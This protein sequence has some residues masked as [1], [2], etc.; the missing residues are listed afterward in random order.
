MGRF[1]VAGVGIAGTAAARALTQRGHNVIVYN[2]QD[3]A[4]LSALEP[5][6]AD[7]VHGE[8]LP[9]HVLA[10]VD[11]V[12]VSPGFPPDHELVLA[13]KRAGVEVYSEPELAWR[14]RPS[15]AAPW[16]AVTGTNGKTTAVTMLAAMLAAAGY[17]SAALGNIGVPLVDAVTGEYDVLAVELSSQQLHWSSRLA[18]E[19]GALINLADD[20]LS[21][22]G[23]F[24]AYAQAKTAVWRGGN[25]VVNADD[26]RVHSLAEQVSGRHYP[27]TMDVP[28]QGQFG[29]I[30]EV[31]V[32]YCASEP[33]ELCAVDQVRPAGRHNVVNA[34]AA[35]TVARV[36]GV[37]AAAIRRGLVNYDPQPHRNVEVGV[38]N[39]V[40][41]VNDSKGTNP[42]ATAAA[43][44][45]YDSI[46][47]VAGGQLKGVDVDELVAHAVPR[48]RA[49][50][51]LGV[52]RGEISAA[53]SRHAPD[54]P[55]VEIA[56]AA[57]HAMSD[58]VMAASGLAQP[59]DVVLL[60]PAAASYDM[61]SGYA[62]RGEY[63]ARAVT[64]LPGAELP[65]SQ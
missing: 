40:R 4:E 42:H 10:S 11:E 7:T 30:D 43:I 21:W 9:D 14:L 13:A 32:D 59:G 45:S 47:W 50:V 55:I 15:D 29:L 60:S 16:L 49:A 58:V 57:P 12:V 1:L 37:D 2:R 56:D 6:V 44:A 38:V 5:V 54:I 17:R 33:V 31:L 8:R 26:P 46:V 24:D 39:G 65:V 25:C 63:F 51:L 23:G 20:H 22:H 28:K 64:N 3:N 62:Q 35:A 41:Y 18:P 53:L 19:V 48:L 34:L 27:F 36:Y 61:F 52:D